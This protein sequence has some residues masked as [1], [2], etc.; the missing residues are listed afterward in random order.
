MSA[1]PPIP[2]NAEWRATC[3]GT[4]LRARCASGRR[5][6][7]KADLALRPDAP[8]QSTRFAPNTK[9]VSA[10]GKRKFSANRGVCSQSPA[11]LPLAFD[12]LAS[13]W[14][15]RLDWR[16]AARYAEAA[17]PDCPSRTCL[18]HSR[19]APHTSV[20]QG[21]SREQGARREGA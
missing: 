9:S 18:P 6:S 11:R 16:H 20:G 17:G 3:C 2:S 15:H 19:A 1:M 13:L 10:D 14:F 5:P 7:R 4:I 8:K 12:V 21:S